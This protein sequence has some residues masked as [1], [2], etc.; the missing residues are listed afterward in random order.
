[1]RGGQVMRGPYRTCRSPLGLA[2]FHPFS[3]IV[4]AQTDTRATSVCVNELDARRHQY[5]FNE[6]KRLRISSKS[7]DFYVG[8]RVPMKAGCAG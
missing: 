1:M 6:L 7:S 5:S 2:S 8:D 3:L 4:F